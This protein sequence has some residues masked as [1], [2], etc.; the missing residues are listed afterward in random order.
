VTVACFHYA[1]NVKQIGGAQAAAWRAFGT[2]AWGADSV[3]AVLGVW[4]AGRSRVWGAWSGWVRAA[5]YLLAYAYGR[6]LFSAVQD[7]LIQDHSGPFASW[8]GPIPFQWPGAH[9]Q[10]YARPALDLLT[11]LMLV[12]VLVPMFTIARGALTDE[13]DA[14]RMRGAFSIASIFGWTTAAAM[15]LVWIR[16]LTWKDVAPETAYSYTTPTQALQEYVVEGLPSLLIEAASVCLLMWGWSGRWWLPCITLAGA[17]LIDS[18][19]HRALYTVL[20][21]AQGS[22][23]SGNVLSGSALEHWSYIAGRTGTAWIA[24]GVARLTGVRFR[25]SSR[26]KAMKAPAESLVR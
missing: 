22:S 23:F 2:F 4:F 1:Y 26:T 17:L 25:R 19:G 24:F 15:I 16:F 9:V 13:S 5:T 3:G 11:L 7:W 18:F 12:W 21:W 20:R 10:D 8:P 6:M 14:T